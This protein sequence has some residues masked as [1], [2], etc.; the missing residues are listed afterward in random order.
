MIQWISLGGALLILLPFAATQL[1]RM[2]MRGVSYQVLN[3][4]GSSTLTGVAAVE[5]QYGFL[6][7]EGVW[8]VMS[9]IGLLRLRGERPQ[10]PSCPAH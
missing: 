7:L 4:L 3:L 9:L 1:Q 10:Q 2:E 5:H 8:A 6:L